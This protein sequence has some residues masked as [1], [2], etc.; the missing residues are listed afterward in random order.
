VGRLEPPITVDAV[1]ERFPASVRGAVV[2]R[3]VD[4][5]PHQ[6]RL[7]HASVA[8]P[9]GKGVRDVVIEE[10]VVDLAPRG[11][12]LVPFD[13]P[14]AG[15]EPGW[16]QVWAEILVDGQRKVRGPDGGKRFLVPWPGDQVRKGPVEASLEL[17]GGVAVRRLECRP[18]R[19][20][21][22]WHAPSDEESELRVI[23]EG[24]RLPELGATVDQASGDRG[25][26]VYP[27]LKQHRSLTFEL[28]GPGTSGRT[29]T[30]ELP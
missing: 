26:V 30:L 25:T 22:R 15:L 13:I 11:E 20:T 3:G 14:F 4:P 18:D 29:G 9:R 10:T 12:I 17:G 16:Y 27:I 1:F 2:I 28:Q 24:E 7:E 21:V 5:D 8:D 23:V 19:A 6:I